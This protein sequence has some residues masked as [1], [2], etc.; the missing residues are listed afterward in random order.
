[1]NK[2]KIGSRERIHFVGIGGI[3]MSG[4]A[5]VMKGLGFKIQGSDRTISPIYDPRI[6][7]AFFTYQEGN[8]TPIIFYCGNPP[9]IR[10]LNKFQ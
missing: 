1:M 4:L 10:F 6:D 9:E 3:G 5:L 7:I 2:S 8:L